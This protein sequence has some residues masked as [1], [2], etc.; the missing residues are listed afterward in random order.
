LIKVLYDH[1]TWVTVIST[2]MIFVTFAQSPFYFTI[3]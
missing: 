1:Q 2:R 3:I